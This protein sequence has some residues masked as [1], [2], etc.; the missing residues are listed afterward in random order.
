MGIIV[1]GLLAMGATAVQRELLRR[2][3][4]QL[5]DWEAVRRIARRR[6]GTEGAA[7][8]EA[9]R[10]AAD[11]FYRA[12]LLRIEPIVA[13][14]IG[15]KLP[16]ALET[17]AVV[18]RFEWIDLNLAT[19]EQ[20]F[21]RVERIINEATTGADT[22]GRAFA[23]ILNRSLGNQQLGFLMAFLARKVLGQYDVS[24]LAAAPAARGRLNFVEP[25]IRASAATLGVPLGEFRTFVALHEATHAF[26][27]EAY[28]WLRDHFA[29]SVGEAIE[30][31][32][33]ETGGLGQRLRG[34]LRGRDGHWLERMMTPGQLSSFRRTQA[35][36][37]LLE[38]YSNHVMNDAGERLLPGF[39]RLHERF[40]RRNEARGALERAIMRLTGLDLKMEQYAAGERF[41]TAVLAVRDR[42]FLNQVWEGPENL[43]DLAEVRHPQSWIDRMEGHRAKE[44]VS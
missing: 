28:P 17:P 27:F 38:G 14:A 25:N 32:A 12:E 36:M 35:L 13:E 18:D 37:S 22:P 41:V 4:T 10:S 33:T 21:G 40:E 29:A 8:S 3:G 23:R 34:A 20:L 43:P 6:L 16:R 39:T 31:M 19:F 7:L 15:A 26:E 9:D 5:I 24:L 2:A 11:A 42:P 44:Q 1:G 30:Q